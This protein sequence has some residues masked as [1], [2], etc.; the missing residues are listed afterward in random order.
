MQT[1]RQLPHDRHNRRCKRR[2]DH[3]LGADGS[4][5]IADLATH[6]QER[7][8]AQG[9]IEA[10]KQNLDGRLALDLSSREMLELNMPLLPACKPLFVVDPKHGSGS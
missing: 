9:D 1:L 8:L 2:T 5:S 3:Q 10:G 6:R 4:R 7:G